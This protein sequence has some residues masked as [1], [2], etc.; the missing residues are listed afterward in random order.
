MYIGCLV[1]FL[2]S[3]I[4][5]GSLNNYQQ[6]WFGDQPLIFNEAKCLLNEWVNEGIFISR[7]PGYHKLTLNS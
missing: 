7:I 3:Q 4:F 1:Y 6:G 5:S 2:N